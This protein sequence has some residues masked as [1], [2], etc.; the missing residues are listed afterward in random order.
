MTLNE[1]QNIGN[2][3]L[4]NYANRD[5]TEK[6][7][8][9]RSKIVTKF[10]KEIID[11]LPEHRKNHIYD[12]SNKKGFIDPL[13]NLKKIIKNCNNKIVA[14][15]FGHNTT[16]YKVSATDV[17]AN[18][19]DTG[20]LFASNAS[21][22]NLPREIRGTVSAGAYYDVDM[23]NAHPVI[24]SLYCQKN[25][26]RCDNLDKYI[27]NRNLILSDIMDTCKIP[28]DVA[29]MSRVRR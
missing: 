20:R 2:I 14:Y 3:I 12:N 28:K 18:E 27:K 5:Y 4:S 16:S 8:L 25:N 19:D 26:I 24:L 21:L 23:I 13:I 9:K 29:K 17:Y 11:L 1:P 7:D 22:Q 6:I 15:P 10:W